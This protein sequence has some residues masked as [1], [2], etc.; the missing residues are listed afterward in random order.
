[1]AATT[2]PSRRRRPAAAGHAKGAR[3]A[4]DRLAGSP[5]ARHQRLAWYGGLAL[6]AALEII[7]WPI[8]IV[9]AV[10]HEIAHR[11]RTQAL[12]ELAEGVEAG[13]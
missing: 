1:M 7:D 8:A 10:G 11:A 13:A 6:M 3:R 5:R 2:R 9:I 12:R 4:V